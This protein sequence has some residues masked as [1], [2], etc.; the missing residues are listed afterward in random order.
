M[1]G[2]VRVPVS[3]NVPRK[4]PLASG[5]RSFNC[6]GENFASMS[7]VF[8]TLPFASSR[9]PPSVNATSPS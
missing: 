3:F 6:K 9:L 8:A 7:I 5:S 2:A 1:F 4:L